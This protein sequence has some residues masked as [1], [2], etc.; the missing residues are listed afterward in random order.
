MWIPYDWLTSFTTLYVRM[1][2]LVSVISQHE[3]T[4][5]LKAHHRN[6]HEKTKLVLYKPLLHF[7]SNL[8]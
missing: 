5:E 7:K 1:R 4:V 3:L 8:K 6:Q 2:A